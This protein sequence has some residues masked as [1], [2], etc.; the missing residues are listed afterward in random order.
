MQNIRYVQKCIMTQDTIV[1]KILTNPDNN[2]AQYNQ[3]KCF[4]LCFFNTVHIVN[5]NVDPGLADNSYLF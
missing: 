5:N 1:C 4:S 2:Y 3:K